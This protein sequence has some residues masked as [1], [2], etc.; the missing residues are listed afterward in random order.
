MGPAVYDPSELQARAAKAEALD[1]TTCFFALYGGDR[2]MTSAAVSEPVG[3]AGIATRFTVGVN[4]APGSGSWVFTLMKGDTPLLPPCTVT[5][6][7]R[8]C[9]STG[10]AAFSPTDRL[11]IKMTVGTGDDAPSNMFSTAAFQL[12]YIVQ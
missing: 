8:T 6:T 5:G 9:Q 4:M 1:W 10:Y 11:S 3:D 7:G 2:G 12:K